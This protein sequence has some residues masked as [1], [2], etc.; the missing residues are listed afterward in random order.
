MIV[1]FRL[2][3]LLEVEFKIVCVCAT[4]F[5]A[6]STANNTWLMQ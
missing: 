5:K 2:R 3:E 6:S 1:V 4:Y